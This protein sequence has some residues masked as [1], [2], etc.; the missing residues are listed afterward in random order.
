MHQ[1]T[2]FRPLIVVGSL[3][4]HP[5]VVPHQE[6]ANPPAMPIDAVRFPKLLEQI[7]QQDS[8]FI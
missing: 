7:A 1:S 5:N 6:I 2:M 4:L 8:T 3:M